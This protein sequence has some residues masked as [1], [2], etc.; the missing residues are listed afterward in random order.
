MISVRVYFSK[1]DAERCAELGYLLPN[2]SLFRSDV[3]ETVQF[4]FKT[5]IRL[6]PS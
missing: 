6:F 5:V 4:S 1:D 3:M 2:S